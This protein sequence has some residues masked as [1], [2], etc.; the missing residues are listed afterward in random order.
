MGAMHAEHTAPMVCGAECGVHDSVEPRNQRIVVNGFGFH[1]YDMQQCVGRSFST[2]REARRTMATPAS[3]KLCGGSFPS[4][5]ALFK[6]LRDENVAT[7]G[8]CGSW[9]VKHGGVTEAA[10]KIAAGELEEPTFSPPPPSRPRE[11]KALKKKAST[12]GTRSSGQTTPGED[13]ES[14]GEDVSA[15]SGVFVPECPGLP[16]ELWVGGIPATHASRRRVSQILYCAIPGNVGIAVPAVR[17]VV[18]R[19]WR[20]SARKHGG[21]SRAG[22]GDRENVVADVGDGDGDGDA[23]KP[24]GAWLGYAFVAFRDAEEAAQAMLH[25]DGKVVR[26]TTSDGDPV[27]ITLSARPATIKGH[28]RRS[29][30][31][32]DAGG[33]D[34]GEEKTRDDDA[35]DDAD[36]RQSRTSVPLAPGADPS[37][38]AIAR[39]WPRSVLARRAE[40]LGY[41]TVEAYLAAEKAASDAKERESPPST[42]AEKKPLPSP[43][44]TRVRG[45]P[46][47]PR[48]LENLRF[49]LENTRWP[50]ASH[51]RGVEAQKYLLVSSTPRAMREAEATRETKTRKTQKSQ[52]TTEDPKN[53]CRHEASDPYGALKRAAYRVLVWADPTFEYDRLA[54]TKNFTGSPHVD[55][56]DVTFQY[57]L[58]LGDFAESGGGE[59][60]VESESGDERWVV[61]TRNRVARVDG[62]FAHWVRGYDTA[63]RVSVSGDGVRGDESGT[64]TRYSVIFYANKPSAATARLHPPADAGFVPAGTRGDGDGDARERGKRAGACPGAVGGTGGSPPGISVALVKC[65]AAILGIGMALRSRRRTS[66]GREG[67]A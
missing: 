7:G 6:H 36:E 61:E 39:A 54:V 66:A 38:F 67:S 64:N 12:R 20:E 31:R 9:C 29:R 45:A 16:N 50:A 30:S 55:K 28:R 46:I 1:P 10:R 42:K 22:D 49:A 65:F 56:E 24:K 34:G 17:H 26:E 57:A 51:R 63:P 14:P 3:C 60:V 23:K 47:P 5:N 18:R 37:R 4:K 52:T 44:Y 32:T 43:T 41:H 13:G 35:D 8:E 2:E 53:P 27:T 25:V 62:R 21:G 58:S 48:L 19:G 40:T 33:K 11:A 59:L 15:T